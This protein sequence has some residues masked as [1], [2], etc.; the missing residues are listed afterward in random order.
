MSKYGAI[1]WSVIWISCA[2]VDISVGEADAVGLAGLGML[3][4]WFNK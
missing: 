2:T 1:V 3:I 4:W